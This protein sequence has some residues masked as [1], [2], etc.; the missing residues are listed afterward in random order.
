M[1]PL[2]KKEI[3]LLLPAWVAA[4][5]VVATLPPLLQFLSLNSV[6]YNPDIVPAWFGLG[7]LLL[8]LATFGQEFSSKTFPVQLSQPIE[9]SR[10]WWIKVSIL[11]V[12]LVSFLL[13]LSVCYKVYFHF[14]PVYHL[15]FPFGVSALFGLVIFSGGL[16]TTL[17][18]HRMLEAFWLTLITPLAIMVTLYAV[19]EYFHW[20]NQTDNYV[21]PAVLLLYSFAGFFWARRLFLLAQDV[22]WT[23][24][25][26]AFSSRK[27]N[28]ALAIVSSYPRHWLSALAWKEL[29]LQQVNIL[30]AVVVLALHLASVVIRQVHPSFANPYIRE[31]LELVWAIWLMMPLLIGSAAVAEERR[32]GIIESQFCLPVSR[33]TQFFVKFSISLVLSLILGGAMPFVIEWT[34]DFNGFVFIVAAV[35][36]F[37]S[38][39]AST[40]VRTALQ[41]IGLTL[42][43]SPVIYLF[44]AAEAIA[45]ATFAHYYNYAQLGLILLKLRLGIP[46]LLFVFVCLMFWNFKWLRPDWKLWRR[47]LIA[48]LA[49]FVA[50][51]ILSHAVYFRAWELLMPIE[52]PYG[53]VRLS[54]S[55]SPKLQVA[56]WATFALLPDG[57]LWWERTS[58]GYFDR[59]LP[60]LNTQRFVGG[61]NWVDAASDGYRITGIQSDGSLWSFQI[62]DGRSPYPLTRIGT[63]TNWLH[64][65]GEHGFLLLKSDHTLWCWGVDRRY[66][67]V[68]KL[69]TYLATPPKPVGKGT[70]WTEV[71]SMGRL[72]ARKD[73]GSIWELSFGPDNENP[74][75]HVQLL[76]TWELPNKGF[77]SSAWAGVGTAGVKP[78]GELWLFIFP[79]NQKEKDIQIGQNTKWKAVAFASD[80]S[81]LALR[82][83]GTLWEWPRF[84]NLTRRSDSLKPF[85]LGTYSGWITLHS[86]WS[87]V[88]VALAADG[89]LW[90]WKDPSEHLWLAPSR[91]PVYL[92]NIF[93]GQ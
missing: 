12:A 82:S 17:L 44:L 52:P 57:R 30:I 42:V 64:V 81:I 33:R 47:N 70:N 45:S 1:S 5:A 80:E 39:Y 37:I 76:E 73:D 2:I 51:S 75:A 90:A 24:G 67:D 46:I 65:T 25:V 22:Q 50:I 77:V 86:T 84:W 56:S 8:A 16:W 23:G 89:N 83:D 35:I 4:L 14:N 88:P 7:C 63:D 32:V 62:Y 93:T 13:A 26:I 71:F 87:S 31:L 3:R 48:V 55:N 43:L 6:P 41:A 68:N 21:I 19:H 66:I 74:E 92:G 29:Q 60:I 58:R 10:I 27:K 78:N 15:P 34:R 72:Y 20:S 59:I 49:A 38:F 9:R 54:A 18:L 36:F 40:L 28:S 11:A 79:D 69:R 61:S 53:P 85:Q 91:K